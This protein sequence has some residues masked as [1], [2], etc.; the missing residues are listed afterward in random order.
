MRPQR[1]EVARDLNETCLN[2]SPASRRPNL[3]ELPNNDPELIRCPSGLNILLNVQSLKQENAENVIH[4][5]HSQSAITLHKPVRS[6]TAT[7]VS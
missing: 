6:Y 7:D 1:A 4:D 3:I 2:A 5:C